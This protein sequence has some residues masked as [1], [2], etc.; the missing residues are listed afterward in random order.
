VCGRDQRFQDGG[1]AKQC[2]GAVGD[3]VVSGGEG[4]RD[5]AVPAV[6]SQRGQELTESRDSV[7]GEA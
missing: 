5:V 2:P 1:R 4:S 6:A 3:V 7:A